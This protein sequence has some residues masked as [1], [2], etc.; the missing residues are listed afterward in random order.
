MPCYACALG[1]GTELS[2]RVQANHHVYSNQENI[3]G[4]RFEPGISVDINFI[5][6]IG[7][8]LCLDI[9]NMTEPG[10]RPRFERS[11]A[12]HTGVQHKRQRSA[13]KW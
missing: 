13:G 9:L 5:T 12:V 3:E 1:E 10:Y 8:K 6:C 4:V 2:A 7:V 11:E